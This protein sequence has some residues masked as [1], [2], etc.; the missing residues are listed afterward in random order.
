MYKR[1]KKAMKA[2]ILSVGFSLV[3]LYSLYGQP[4]QTAHVD[5][6][7]DAAWT[8]RR[9]IEYA[10]QHNLQVKRTLYSVELG[11]VNFTQSKMAMLPALN[12]SSSYT[13]SS[14]RSIGLQNQVTELNTNTLSM[15]L[16]SSLLLWN[17][18]RLFYAY[19]ENGT[20]REALDQDLIKARNDVILNVISIYLNLIFNEELKDNAAL[21]LSSTQ[22]ELQR[23]RRLAEAGS[24]PRSD[25]LNLEAQ[26]ATNELNLVESENAVNVSRLQLKQALQIPATTEMTLEVPNLEGLENYLFD[27]TVTEIFEIAIMQM[28]E[29]KSARLRQQKATYAYKSLRGAYY[30][31]LSA[32]GS[33]GTFYQTFPDYD[34]IVPSFSD[35]Y[36]GNQQKSFGFTLDIPIFNGFSTR[37]N[38]QRAV[39]ERELADVT[40]QETENSLRQTIETAYN[41]AVAASKSYTASVK[42]VDALREAFRMIDRRREA[43]GANYVEYQLAEND[44]FQAESD[45]LRAKYDLIFKTKILDFYQGKTIDF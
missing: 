6:L 2:L 17:G 43:G 21:Q 1:K 45:M 12:G 18:F 44:L 35:Q 13:L 3:T 11:Q 20:E 37:A 38:V 23:T 8:L 15:G 10:I 42:K 7:Q 26:L 16:S 32:S 24:V 40:Y 36:S 33:I 19:K 27:R 30:P 22:Q 34:D 25:V 29:M 5:T 9:C 31:K 41:D 4:S 39:I 14:G 28:P